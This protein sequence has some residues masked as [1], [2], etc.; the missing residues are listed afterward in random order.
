MENLF[1][2]SSLYTW[3]IL[4]LLIFSARIFDVT[5][6]TFRIIFISR[7]MKYLSAGVSFFE[8]LIW[9]MAISQIFK[10]LNNPVCYVAYAGGFASGSFLGVYIADKMAMGKAVLR[11]I[12]AKDASALID[13]LKSENYGLTTLDAQGAEGPVKVI[14][15]II[16]KQDLKHIKELVQQFN[17]NAFY[18]VEDVRFVSEGVF[19]ER[20]SVLNRNYFETFRPHR[21]SK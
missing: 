2:D 4:P 21:K 19:P 3:A 1:Q 9:L 15:S 11:I 10:N 20:P 13:R 14:F 8:I 6:G 18:S 5:L 17:P 12:T 16:K 7:G